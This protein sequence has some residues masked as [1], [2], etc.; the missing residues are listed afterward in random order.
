M[1][2][3]LPQ[4][5]LSLQLIKYHSHPIP[6]LHHVIVNPHLPRLRQGKEQHRHQSHCHRWYQPL[7][8]T[9]HQNIIRKA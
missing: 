5:H 8:D 1:Y 6:L 3:H 7:H 4:Y 9:E 2:Q